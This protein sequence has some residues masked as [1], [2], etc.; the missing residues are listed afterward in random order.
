MSRIVK[1]W[2]I[3]DVEKVQDKIQEKREEDEGMVRVAPEEEIHQ[4]RIKRIEP[5]TAAETVRQEKFPEEETTAIDTY[6]D[7]VARGRKWTDR[8]KKEEA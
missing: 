2:D 5:P 8:V 3:P 4:R 6:E 7:P 1:S